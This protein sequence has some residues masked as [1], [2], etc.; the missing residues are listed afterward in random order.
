[1]PVPE[2][3]E[4]FTTWTSD[5]DD[6]DISLVFLCGEL[7]ASSVPGF[8]ADMQ[9]VIKQ[10]KHTVMDVHLLDYVDST[11]VGAILSTRNALHES[12]RQMCLIGCHGLLT[13]ILQLTRIDR[14]LCCLDNLEAAT[15]E[16]RAG[17]ARN[18]GRG[19]TA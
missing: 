3:E 11:G 10:G 1:M 6:R 5:L 4:I 17:A 9:R 15:A 16:I 2:S 14:D 18:K 8:L 7:D 13:K 19:T 12:G